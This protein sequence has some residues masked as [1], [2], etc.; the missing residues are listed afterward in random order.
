MTEAQRLTR[1]DWRLLLAAIDRA[2]DWT[3]SSAQGYGSVHGRRFTLKEYRSKAAGE[4][5][6]LMRLKRVR[7]VI[8]ERL[9]Q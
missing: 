6:F 2:A 5:R 9:K 8:L 1:R 4:R 3:E 7:S